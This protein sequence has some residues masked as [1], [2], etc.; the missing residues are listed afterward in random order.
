MTFSQPQLRVF[1]AMAS[2]A[3]Q[4]EAKS[5]QEAVKSTVA[6][7]MF[8]QFIG[9]NERAVGPADAPNLEPEESPTLETEEWLREDRARP[10]GDF[11]VGLEC[12]TRD[13]ILLC[14]S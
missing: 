13:W 14:R 5:A 4:A 2:F 3:W 11:A 8:E 12:P 7:A 10:F 9:R 6:C 1:F